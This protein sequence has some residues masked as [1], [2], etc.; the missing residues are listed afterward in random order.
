VAVV[1]APSILHGRGFGNLVLL[2][3]E[4]DLPVDDLS[5]RTA[6]D[7]FPARVLT[8]ADVRRFAG[9]AGAPGDRTATPSPTPPPGFFGR[10]V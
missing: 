1:A 3:S 8:G 2:G 6:A 9:A 4:E 7:P 10:P 5:R